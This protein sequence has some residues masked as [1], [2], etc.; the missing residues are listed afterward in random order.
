MKYILLLIVVLMLVLCG[1]QRSEQVIHLS[2]A[3][4]DTQSIQDATD[5][6]EIQEHEPLVSEDAQLLCLTQTQ[7][8]AQE[9]AALYGIELVCWY[10]GL[11]TFRTDEDPRE[12][13]RRG[14]EQGWKALELNHTVQLY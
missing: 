2:Q 6:Q 10:D 11:A 1:C 9:I 5:P 13:I 12:V 7:K 4:Q 14:E 3:T 8:E